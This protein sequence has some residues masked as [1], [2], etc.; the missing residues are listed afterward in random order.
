[1]IYLDNGATSFHK[2]PQVYRAVTEAMRTCANPGRGGYGAAMA[3]S[4]KLYACREAAGKLFSCQP[5]QVVLTN[6]CTHGLNIAIHSLFRPGSRVVVTG[7]EHNA[8]T[9]PL[10][11][12]DARMVVAGRKLFD[13]ADTLSEWE[14]ALNRGRTGR[15]SPMFPMSLAIS[16][17]WSK[18]QNAAGNGGFPLSWTRLSLP[19]ACRF[20][21]KHW[22]PN[23]L[24]CRDTRVCWGL[25]GRGCCCAGT[26]ENPCFGAAP[27]AIPSIRIC[28]P[29]CRSGWRP[30]P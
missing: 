27:A 11:G 12:L 4:E 2:P 13:W 28:L 21:W 20:L 26:G 17:R 16:C 23:S 22:E 5:E 18:W 15:S 8:V 6:N 3:A 24:P 9:R 25:R 29:T 1:M 19:E 10:H 14:K 30:E 7:F